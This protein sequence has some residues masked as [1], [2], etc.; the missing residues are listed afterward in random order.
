[1]SLKPSLRKSNRKA[2]QDDKLSKE[3]CKIYKGQEPW[4]VFSD[5]YKAGYG[6]SYFPIGNKVW[7][8]HLGGG[9]DSRNLLI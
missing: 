6:Q 9:V 7:I 2:Y 4:N 3:K 1:M 5:S 8:L